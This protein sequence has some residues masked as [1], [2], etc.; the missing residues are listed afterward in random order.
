MNAEDE[1]WHTAEA[2][3]EE[4][5]TVLMDVSEDT[6]EFLIAAC[7]QCVKWDTEMYSKQVPSNKGGRYKTH[8]VDMFLRFVIS[9]ATKSLDKDLA[10]MKISVLDA[11]TAIVYNEDR[12]S[13]EYN[14]CGAD[15]KCIHTN[16]MHKEEKIIASV[17]KSLTPLTNQKESFSQA[18]P[19]LFGSG[20][21]HRSK[22]FL[23]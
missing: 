1:D 11:L 7:T 18:P 2:L 10:N 3:N 21:A 23:D 12:M 17:N 4:E 13:W 22:D 20:F 15:W 14:S 9:Q 6:R 8:T 5:N 19:D 16:F